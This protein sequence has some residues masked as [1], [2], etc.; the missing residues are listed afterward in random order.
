MVNTETTPRQ[1]SR[2]IEVTL[3]HEQEGMY[4]TQPFTL[5]A[6]VETLTV[7][8]HYER[9]QEMQLDLPG[10]KFT[11]RKRINTIDLGL[12]AADGHQVGVSGSNKSEITIS[13][14]AATPGYQPCEL[15]PGEWKLLIGAYLVA[16]QGVKITYELT[17]THKHLRL[18]KGDL[19]SHT[20]AS[21]GVQTAEA[22]VLR[23]QQNGLDFLAI[24]DHNQPITAEALPQV[25]G[26]TLIP[27]FE[28]THYRA[29]SN[30]LGCPHPYEGSFYA[31]TIEEVRQRFDSAH[32]NGATIV[33]NHPYDEECP[34]LF[35]M[36][37]L[38]FDLLE[39]WNAPMRESNLKAVALWQSMLAAGKKVPACGGS[40]FHRDTPFLFIGGPTTCVYALSNS[41]RDILSAL[42]QGHAYIVFE[43]PGPSLE[44]HAGEAILGDS[45]AWAEVKDVQLKLSGLLTGDVVRLVTGS[46]AE[47]LLQAPANGDCELTYRM[48]EPGFARVELLR[49]FLPGLPLL[50]ALLSNPIYFD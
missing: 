15:E 13:A 12:I 14:T 30:F 35:D 11:Q 46:R 6:D 22:L 7:R 17:F 34:L 10:G 5:P 27:S 23:A 40:D 43:A 33:L 48:P 16:P 2:V 29:H 32:A 18:L 20:L 45:V 28:W 4:L 26:I 47:T 19:H 1:S 25:P 37:D 39:I 24:T 38:P 8:Y 44:M 21:D 49:A 50:P 31:N 3:R 36:A 9:N 41:P 42:R